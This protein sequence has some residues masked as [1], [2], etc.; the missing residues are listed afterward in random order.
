MI[1]T[2]P[3]K[4]EDTKRFGADS[5]LISKDENEM[6]KHQNSFDFLLN[7]VPVR[8][9]INPYLKLLKRDSTMV[10]VRAIEP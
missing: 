2:S 7:T 8:H 10:M 9:D 4:V 6:E 5:V 3:R 1:T